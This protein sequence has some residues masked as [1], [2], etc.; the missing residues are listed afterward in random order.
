MK[1]SSKKCL[2]TVLVVMA[3]IVGVSSV[4][5]TNGL[6]VHYAFEGNLEDSTGNFAAGQPIAHQIGS[7]IGVVD[8]PSGNQTIEFMDGIDGLAATFDGTKGILL[9]AGLIDSNVYTISLWINPEVLTQHTTTLFG[10]ASGNS[11]ISIVPVGPTT[12]DT[13]LWSGE[14]WYDAATGVNIPV[15]EWSHFVASVNKG[16]VK[17]YINGQEEFA[18]S[19]FPDIF[20]NTGGE[21]VFTLAVNWWDAPFRG[22]ID[23]VKIYNQALTPDQL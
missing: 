1:L 7:T 20:S 5:A 21:S 8:Q 23:E 10:A 2:I 17:V 6:V 13:M 12:N 19:N 16:N 14:A 4:S 3:L 18:G 15:G 11:W 9:P 22:L